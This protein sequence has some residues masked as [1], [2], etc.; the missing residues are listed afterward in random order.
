MNAGDV[1]LIRYSQT[2]I[3]LI[4][5]HPP[6]VIFDPS[7]I[8]SSFGKLS[9]ITLSI[10]SYSSNTLPIALCNPKSGVDEIL[11]MPFQS[12]TIILSSLTIIIDPS[13]SEVSIERMIVSSIFY[14]IELFFA[15][16][17]IISKSSFR[18]PTSYLF[19]SSPLFSLNLIA[20]I[21]LFV[22]TTQ[23][24][25]ILAVRKG[26][27]RPSWRESTIQ[28][29]DNMNK[30]SCPRGAHEGCV[31][32]ALQKSF[33]TFLHI[34]HSHSNHGRFRA[35]EFDDS[36]MGIDIGVVVNHSSHNRIG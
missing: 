14:H 30:Q 26:C 24:V 11:R 35:V 18:R 28:L 33:H 9:H 8:D 21:G 1:G 10:S 29:D 6:S 31:Q 15:I 20:I 17:S 4:S 36:F 16:D 34:D 7:I 25:H 32:I 27:L 19:V 2:S 3:R 13:D 5:S 22:E 23:N 12:P